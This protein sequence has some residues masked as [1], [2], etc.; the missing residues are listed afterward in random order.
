MAA[1]AAM[2]FL[3]LVQRLQAESGTSGPAITTLVGASGEALRLANWISNAYVAIQNH[4]EDWLWMTQDVQFDTIANQQSYSPLTTVF[5]VPNSTG[6]A[7]FR[8]WKLNPAQEES[9]FRIWLK[10][11][12]FHNETWLGSIDYTSFR[13]YYQFGARRD[14]YSRPVSITVDPQQNLLLGLGPNDVYTVV[15]KYVQAPQMLALDA[16]VPAMPAWAHMLIVW[17]ALKN[18]GFY[19]AAPDVLA[20][21]GNEITE[22]LDKLESLQLPPWQFAEP[23]A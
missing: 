8:K 10:S 23:L 7:D 17:W 12:G 21:A 22:L 14:T 3:Q 4:R 6:L 2:T 19:E 20:Q 13:D 18:Y 9:T 1:V 11:A 5:T 16:D 15:G